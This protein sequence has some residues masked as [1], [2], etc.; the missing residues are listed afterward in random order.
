MDKSFIL[1]EIKSHLNI[2]TDSEFAEF[3]GVK[4]PTIASWRKRNS[5]DYDLII[6][7]CN[8]IDANWLLTGK[9]SMLKQELKLIG[10]QKS[11]EATMDIQDIPLYNLEA[12]AGLVELFRS[13]KVTSVL[14][15]IRIPGIPKCDGGLSITGDS[16]YP[17]LKSGDIVL[18]KEIPVEQQ[19]I[20]F[21]EMYLLGVRVDEWEE[22]ITVK[23][24]Q[25]SEKGEEYVKLVSQNQYHHPKDVLL[26]NITAM[27]IIKAS[28][29]FNTMF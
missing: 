6:T 18:Y 9:G 8:E 20:F 4:Q 23:Y 7:K 25:K 28:I 15:S 24:V 11:A 13:E 22:M 14:D 26:S 16:M 10:N 27:A 21:G 5:L 29:R 19:S 2:K 1:N 12:T 17:L 3:L